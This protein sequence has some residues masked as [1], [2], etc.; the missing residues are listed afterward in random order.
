MYTNFA[1]HTQS[2][3]K[4]FRNSLDFEIGVVVHIMCNNHDSRCNVLLFQ[5]KCHTYSNA[6]KYIH[7]IV[8]GKHA[9]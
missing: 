4:H 7:S 5:F 9:L 3:C 6:L 1:A 2:S 8:K